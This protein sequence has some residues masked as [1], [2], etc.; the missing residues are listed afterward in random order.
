MA[1]AGFTSGLGRATQTN[2]LFD[3][4]LWSAAEIGMAKG[5]RP[6]TIEFP[7]PLTRRLEEDEDEAEGLQ[8]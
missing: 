2:D 3:G 4:H 7:P 1:P 8:K 5:G 6:I